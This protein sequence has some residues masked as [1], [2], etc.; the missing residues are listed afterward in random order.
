M[1][2]NLAILLALGGGSSEL[3]YLETGLDAE[4]RAFPVQKMATASYSFHRPWPIQNYP[5]SIVS[6]SRALPPP[7]HRHWTDTWKL[8]VIALLLY[9]AS[10]LGTSKMS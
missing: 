1:L 10:L 8:Q 3:R 7:F 2:A 4:N 6:Y 5:S 9:Q